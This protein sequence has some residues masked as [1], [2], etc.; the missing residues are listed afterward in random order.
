MTSMKATFTAK[1]LKVAQYD[2]QLFKVVEVNKDHPLL[3]KFIK[4]WEDMKM[5]Y[6][7]DKYLNTNHTPLELQSYYRIQVCFEEFTNNEGKDIIFINK[8][9][10]KPVEYV[11]VCVDSEDESDF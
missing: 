11:E 9:R 4:T 3:N 5:I 6:L 8:I 7:K 1:Y 10:H 2:S